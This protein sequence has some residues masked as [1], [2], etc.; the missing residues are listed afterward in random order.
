MNLYTYCKHCK[1]NI[2]IKFRD[3]SRP[4]LQIAKVDEFYVKCHYCG[5]IEKKYAT[6][7]K[8]E[9]NIAIVLAGIAI[10]ISARIFLW[11]HFGTAGT[12]SAI[13]PILFWKDQLNETRS[14]NSYLL[15]KTNRQKLT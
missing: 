1:K 6:D 7:F 15:R 9:S 14:S 4:E 8:T 13:I 11:M 12:M 3:L 2:K 10:G 5:K